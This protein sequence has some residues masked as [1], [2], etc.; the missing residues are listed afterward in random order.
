MSIAARVRLDLSSRA[1]NVSLVRQALGGLADATGLSPAD[2]NDIG[3]AVTEA[4]NNASVHAYDGAE[5][6]L[7]VELHAG[8]RTM[9]ATVRDRGVGFGVD[10]SQASFP[11][12]LDGELLGIGLPSIQGLAE[13][14]RWSEPSDGGTLVEMWFSTDGMSWTGD[15]DLAQLERPAIAEDERA[16]TIELGM[17]PLA[18]TRGVLPRVLRATAA[19]AGFS[20]ERHSSAQRVVSV[21]LADVSSW[22]PSGAVQARL[23]VTGGCIE[24]AVGPMTQAAASRLAIA[25]F[26][27]APRLSTSTESLGAGQRLVVRLDR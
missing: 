9:L 25:V 16:R 17:A 6:V 3:I 21:L 8:E 26:P 27:I 18:V 7:E 12:D 1:A 24:L 5:G 20:F 4:C 23:A 11:T 2:L 15:G 14:A 10:V 22:A 19:Q 13:R